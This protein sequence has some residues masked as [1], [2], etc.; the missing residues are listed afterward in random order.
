MLLSQC[1]SPST[2][3]ARFLL[4]SLPLGRRRTDLKGIV[5]IA[6]YRSERVMSHV[7]AV[8][9][10]NHTH[11][12]TS[13]Q[14]ET[15]NRRNICMRSISHVTRIWLSHVEPTLSQATVTVGT[16]KQCNSHAHIAPEWLDVGLA[17]ND[18]QRHLLQETS[19]EKGP[20]IFLWQSCQWVLR[21]D[22]SASRLE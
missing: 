7:D 19:D 15:P 11:I 21:A 18:V 5:E 8:S 20:A 22:S 4:L 14:N 2:P 17:N 13:C 1:P 12:N 10:S 6:G 3:L 9:Q 16:R